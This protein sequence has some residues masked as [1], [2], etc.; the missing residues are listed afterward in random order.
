M[1][2]R[3]LRVQMYGLTEREIAGDARA[4]PLLDRLAAQGVAAF[5]LPVSH[6][7]RPVAL[8]RASFAEF[9][10]NLAVSAAQRPV[11]PGHRI[12]PRSS[13]SQTGD[14]ASTSG[15]TDTTLGAHR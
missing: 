11:D 4:E 3:V 7:A 12:D 6:L 1:A 8:I 14:P 15:P 10:S 13:I 9:C 2:G 5:G